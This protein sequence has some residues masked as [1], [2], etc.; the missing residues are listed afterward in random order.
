MFGC[1]PWPEQ[2]TLAAVQLDY[3]CP[4]AS[5]CAEL[6]LTS[7][8][9]SVQGPAM[10]L[11]VMLALQLV[12]LALLRRRA[13][14]STAICDPATH[15]HAVICGWWAACPLSS[16]TSKPEMRRMILLGSAQRRAS[17]SNGAFLRCRELP[18]SLEIRSIR[19]DIL[20]HCGILE[21]ASV[22]PVHLLQAMVPFSCN[23]HGWGRRHEGYA[24]CMSCRLTQ[25]I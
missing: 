25:P 5:C 13:E 17:C 4:V 16:G 19:P 6:M 20:E 7:A 21:L 14:A 23:A 3:C 22:F 15:M 18:A 10:L 11:S 24:G 12:E 8:W 9:G 1:A 2:H